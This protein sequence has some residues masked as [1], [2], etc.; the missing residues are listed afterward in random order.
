MALLGGILERSLEP[1]A[2][3]RRLKA[4]ETDDVRRP[5]ST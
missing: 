1:T 4:Q 2:L 5:R 3:L